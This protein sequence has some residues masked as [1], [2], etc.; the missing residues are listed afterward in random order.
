MFIGIPKERMG[1]EE[2]IKELVL[3]K[4]NKKIKTFVGLGIHRG[5]PNSAQVN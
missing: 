1:M 3:I 5:R 2:V 4:K